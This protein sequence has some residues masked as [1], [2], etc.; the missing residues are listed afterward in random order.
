MCS[1][2]DSYKSKGGVTVG[3]RPFIN[4]AVA[5]F[6]FC[7]GYLTNIEIANLPRF[8]MK[9]I[10][11]VAVPYI[12]WSVLHTVIHGTYN[13]FWRNLLT[14]QANFPYYYILVY[15]QFVILTPLIGKLIISRYKWLGFGITPLAL[16]ITRYIPVLMDIPVSFPFNETFFGVWFLYYYLG[17]ML[18][19]G[20]LKSN[21]TYKRI[22]CFYAGTLILSEIEGYIW[23]GLGNFDMAT[24]QLR[25]TSMLT[26]TAVCT[27]AYYY[28]KDGKENVKENIATKM[29][30]IIGNC[31]FGIYLSHIAVKI[32]LQKIPGYNNLAFPFTSI[33]LLIVSTGCVMIGNKILGDKI[34]RYVGLN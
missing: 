31:S 21:L 16:I 27:L 20:Y 9:R 33:V 10:I 2:Y 5:L 32:V 26:S 7:S 11:R 4:F 34:G 18:G 8:Y 13:S 15:I 12:V 22:F 30:V 6:I 24:T 1:N 19:N 23:Y 3:I 29:L 28:I 25:F 14:G 17:M